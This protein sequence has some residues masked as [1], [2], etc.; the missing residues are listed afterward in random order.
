MI[1]DTLIYLAAINASF[2]LF[3]GAAFLESRTYPDK[4]HGSITV[5]ETGPA[6]LVVGP[7]PTFESFLLAGLGEVVVLSAISYGLKLIG[8]K[9]YWWVPQIS[10]SIYHGY[11]GIENIRIHKNAMRYG[12][13]HD[14]Y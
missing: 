3:D 2:A 5:E 8:I 13:E 11:L 4:I 7:Y 1:L 10:I 14:L 6:R 12:R 9:K